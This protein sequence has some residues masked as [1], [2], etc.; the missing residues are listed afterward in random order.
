MGIKKS[1]GTIIPSGLEEII[2][3]AVKGKPEGV[4][5][6]DILDRINTIGLDYGMKEIGIGSLYPTLKRLEKQGLIEGRWGNETL[7]EENS[8]AARRK[9]YRISAL[10]EAS[11]REVREFKNKLDGSILGG[12]NNGLPLN[13]LINIISRNIRI[14]RLKQ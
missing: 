3:S 2:L 7:V 1:N 11:L 12:Q 9:Y 6:L 10:G 14:F 8:G 13:I 4:Y 5:G